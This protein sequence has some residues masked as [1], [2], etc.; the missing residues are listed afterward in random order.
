MGV[1]QSKCDGGLGCV[2]SFTYTIFLH[3]F[4]F[5]ERAKDTNYTLKQVLIPCRTWCSQ[6]WSEHVWDAVLEFGAKPPP[7]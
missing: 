2:S 3:L 4:L 6:L 7:N 1:L 5:S